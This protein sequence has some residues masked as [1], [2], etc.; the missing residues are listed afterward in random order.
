MTNK[1]TERYPADIFWSDEDEGFVALA[2]DLPGCSAWGATQA[3]AI[4]EL[5]QAIA[6]SIDALSAAGNAIPPPSKPATE[7]QFSGKIL[8]RIPRGLHAKLA[9][10][11]RV[12]GVSLN[13]YISYLL[14][15]DEPAKR[16]ESTGI[17]FYSFT[18]G[19]TTSIQLFGGGF[20]V[21]TGAHYPNKQLIIY[22]EPGDAGNRQVM[23]IAGPRI[24][25]IP[26]E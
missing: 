8:L 11:A 6:A 5:Q 16:I 17:G 1:T 23:T 21:N 22:G 26:R 3:D 4:A 24:S 9:A 25:A 18:L 10:N 12:E 13:Q 14:A 19:K 20:D 7:N 15:S 2:R